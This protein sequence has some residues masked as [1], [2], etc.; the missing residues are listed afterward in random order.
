MG[1]SSIANQDYLRLHAQRLV[2]SSLSLSAGETMLQCRPTKWLLG[3]I[4]LAVVT[5]FALYG[6]RDQIEHD[7]TNRT[8]AALQKAGSTWAYAIFDGRNAVLKGLTFSRSDRDDALKVIENVWGVREVVDRSN[9]IA[10]PDTYTWSAIKREQRIKIRGHV[11][12]EDGRRTILGFVKAT[13]PDLEVD[14]KMVIAGGAP[15]Q[16]IWLG[17]VSFALLQLGQ[18][19]SG[20][21]KMAGTD[22]RIT[23]VA[24]N[25]AAYQD[26]QKALIANLPAGTTLKESNIRP[27]VVKPYSWRAKYVGNTVTLT[28]FVPSE[29]MRS[30]ILQQTRNL[31]A[32]VKI[33]DRMALAA[34]EPEAWSWAVSASLTQLHRLESGRAELNDKTLS[35]LGKAADK[36]TAKDVEASIRN[37]LPSAYRST[38]KVNVSVEN[39][40]AA[41]GGSGQSQ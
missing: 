11:P 34:G 19:A 21:V 40:S 37:G 25:S 18:L 24:K 3:L 41:K 7:L 10:S 2:C 39:S 22:I 30:R 35:F 15:P 20:S 31:F 27:P 14:D 13:M 5:A 17:S 33:N 23:G 26:I 9:L 28:G 8:T 16:Q 4:P 12:T 38:E 36:S 32:G 1:R 6:Q 29:N